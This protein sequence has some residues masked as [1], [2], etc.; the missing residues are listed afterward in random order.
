MYSTSWSWVSFNLGGHCVFAITS[1]V[2]ITTIISVQGV[3]LIHFGSSYTFLCFSSLFF[4]A[5]CLFTSLPCL[6]LFFSV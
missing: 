3:A 4:P 5:A 2:A 6:E 1:F